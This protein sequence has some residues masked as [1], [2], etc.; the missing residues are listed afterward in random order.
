MQAV[1][2]Q[3]VKGTESVIDAV[4]V[5]TGDVGTSGSAKV[6]RR[7]GS[8]WQCHNLDVGPYASSPAIPQTNEHLCMPCEA[9]TCAPALLGANSVG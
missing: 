6:S 1:K 9:A 5:M 7:T 2:E 4:G 3:V 8:R